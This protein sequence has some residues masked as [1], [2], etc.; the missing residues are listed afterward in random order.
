M[1]DP[2]LAADDA[3]NRIVNRL[4]LSFGVAPETAKNMV[5]MIAGAVL[6]AI[7]SCVSA[8]SEGMGR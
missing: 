7:T 1:T 5:P 2:K 8:P 3:A 4:V 6:A